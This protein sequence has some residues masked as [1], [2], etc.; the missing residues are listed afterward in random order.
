MTK[1]NFLRL[2]R[3]SVPRNDGKGLDSHLHGNDT[4]VLLVSI[5]F[6]GVVR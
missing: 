1:Y 6:R 3:D 4:D 2:F 5:Y